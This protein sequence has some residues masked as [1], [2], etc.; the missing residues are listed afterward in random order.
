MFVYSSIIYI[1]KRNFSDGQH[2][3]TNVIKPNNYHSLKIIE[4]KTDYDIR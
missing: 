2:Y 4:H 3:S 1:M